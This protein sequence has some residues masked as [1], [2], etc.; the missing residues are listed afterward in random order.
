[1]L[2]YMHLRIY[3]LEHLS[4]NKI[5][6]P[7][8]EIRVSNI[9]INLFNRNQFIPIF[10]MTKWSRSNELQ[11]NKQTQTHWKEW[12]DYERRKRRGREERGRDNSWHL[13]AAILAR[14]ICLFVVAA[15]CYWNCVCLYSFIILFDYT[16]RTRLWTRCENSFGDFRIS[17][18]DTEKWDINFN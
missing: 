3:K 5:C 8:K 14:E 18:V 12:I 13:T 15:L 10:S 1:M 17:I 16:R 7:M 11:I 6:L 9:Q 4:T 2:L